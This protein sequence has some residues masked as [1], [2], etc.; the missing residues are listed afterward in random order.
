LAIKLSRQGFEKILL[1]SVPTSLDQF[2]AT[3]SSNIESLQKEWKQQLNSSQVRLQWDPDHDLL[4]NK[5]KRRAIQLGLK[6]DILK[7]YSN[8]WIISIEDI[9]EFVS[10]QYELIKSNRSYEVRT[11]IEQI[12][13]PCDNLLKEKL[14]ISLVN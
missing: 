13:E 3:S 5:I 12:Y 11:P 8:E 10:E 6:G 4:G 1:E 2:N 9:T 14:G 7:K